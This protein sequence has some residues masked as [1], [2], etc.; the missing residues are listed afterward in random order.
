MV[1]PVSIGAGL[2]VFPDTQKKTAWK[3]IAT[4]SF[5]SGPRVETYQPMGQTELF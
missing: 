4:E 1:F 2:R 3:L 5:A